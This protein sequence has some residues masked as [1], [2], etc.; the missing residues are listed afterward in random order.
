MVGGALK[1]SN[2]G[3]IWPVG[4]PVICPGDI[5]G[6]SFPSMVMS[7]EHVFAVFYFFFGVCK[8]SVDN[9]V[10]GWVVLFHKPNIRNEAS[11]S[12]VNTFA[13]EIQNISS[14]L[15]GQGKFSLMDFVIV[16]VILSLLDTVPNDNEV[17]GRQSHSLLG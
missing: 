9:E 1:T 11:L 5:D 13:N 10:L 6:V 14:F 12:S 7:V 16:R 4:I 3:G 17:A 15:C 2:V 8:V